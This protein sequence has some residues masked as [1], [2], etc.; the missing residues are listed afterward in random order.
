MKKVDG[1]YEVVLPLGSG[2]SGEVF[3]VKDPGGRKIALKFLKSWQPGATEEEA[4]ESFKRE[5]R[6]LKDL[7]HPGIARIL[8]FGREKE[9]GRY[10]FTAELIEGKDFFAAT[11]GK[12]PDAIENLFVQ[13][14]RALEYL[15]S[16]GVFHLDIKP[17]NL[18]VTAKGETKLIDFGLAGERFRGKIAGTPAYMAPEVIC[19]EKPDGRADLYSLGIVFYSALARENPFRAATIQ[20]TLERQKKLNPPPIAKINPQTPSYLNRILDRLLAKNRSERY[21]TGGQVIRDLNLLSAKNYAVET[22]ETLQSYLPEEGALVGRKEELG[23]AQRIC[24]KLREMPGGGAPIRKMLWIRGAKGTGKSRFLREL[25]YFCQLNDLKVVSL[26]PK[27]FPSSVDGSAIFLIDD[28][29]EWTEGDEE[30]WVELLHKTDV[31]A[32]ITVIASVP[33]LQ[34]PLPFARRLMTAGSSDFHTVTLGN[35]NRKELEEYLVS[36]TGL[37]TPPAP[38]IDGLLE[39]TEGNPLFVSEILKS[40]IAGGLLFDREGRWKPVAWEDFGIDFSKMAVPE[41]LKELFKKIYREQTGPRK[42]ILALV[43]LLRREVSLRELQELIPEKEFSD[44]LAAIHQKGV[45]PLWFDV[46]EE[47]LDSRE[48]E[49]LHDRIAAWFE[50]KGESKEA[51]LHWGDG[52]DPDKAVAALMPVAKSLLEG[53]KGR[54]A[55]PL[56]QKILSRLA[57]PDSRSLI[58]WHIGLGEAYLQA[59]DYRNAIEVFRKIR[60]LLAGIENRDENIF[61]K[62]DIH[63]KL[64]G[65]FLKLRRTE[66][67]KENI[68]AGLTL[69]ADYKDDPIRRMVLENDRGQVACQEGDLDRAEKIFVETHRRWKELP[70]REREKVINNDLGF[71]CLLK[72]DPERAVSCLEEQLKFFGKLP[73]RYPEA[74][75]HYNLAEA[76]FALKDHEKTIRHYERVIEL[77]Q[78]IKS[79]DLLL[80]AYNG[81]GNIYSQKKEAAKGIEYYTRALAIAQKLEDRSSQAAIHCNLGILY[82]ERGEFTEAEH[83]LLGAI[84]ILKTLKER[85]AYDV[86]YLA[87]AHLELGSLL[88]QRKDFEAAR[89]H[90]RDA[91]TLAEEHPPLKGLKFWIFYEL[92]LLYRD[93]GR[94]EEFREHL[95]ELKTMAATPDEMRKIDAIEAPPPSQAGTPLVSSPPLSS[96]AWKGLA[97]ILRFLSGEQDLDFLLKTILRYA[98]E[99]S[100]AETSLIL[101]VRDGDEFEVRSALQTAVDNELQTFST[102][103]ARKVIKERRPVVTENAQEDGRF[104]E[105]RS[106][107]LLG[108]RSVLALPIATPGKVIGVLYLDTRI[109]SSILGNTETLELLQAFADQAGLA[110]ENARLL[111][112]LSEAGRRLEK[113][114]SETE[115]ELS[116]ARS[117]LKEESIRFQTRYSYKNIVTRSRKMQELF[118]LL[119]KVTDT[120]IGVLIQGETGTGKELIAR[121]LHYNSSRKEKEFVAVNCGAI[122]AELMES[123]LF[124]HKAGAFTG[125]TR[126]KIG[127]CEAADGGTLFL[128]EVGELSLP[129]QVKLLR[130]LQEKE[131]RRVGETQV[132][133]ADVRIV[134][135]THQDLQAKIRE[136]KFRED[137]FFR[138]CE[139]QLTVPPLRERKEDIPLLVDRFLEDCREEMKI[140]KKFR[141]ER[142]LL[143]RMIDYPWPGNVRE[144]ENLVRVA[145][146]LAENSVLSLKS[147]PAQSPLIKGGKRGEESVATSSVMIDGRNLYRPGWSWAD[148]EKIF[149]SHAYRHHQYRAIPTAQAVGL[150][151]PT[152][153][154]KIREWKLEDPENPV[155]DEPFQYSTEIGLEEFRAKT[156]KAAL[157]HHK[158]PYAAL[159]ALGVSQGYF[160]KIIKM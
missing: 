139:I 36:L 111:K 11:E 80:R 21:A 153:Y 44:D 119:D 61:Y 2:M 92:T 110:I 116:L 158:R 31:P 34:N 23:L 135:A 63:E 85:S 47:L 106:V 30:K 84:R 54:E 71:V 126:D 12:N 103:I 121:A 157:E 32:L 122:P 151:P 94:T 29:E 70:V 24:L 65:V 146:A 27:N 37:E 86:T 117:L 13:A 4:L 133:R 115:G 136:G 137:L 51:A 45:N 112:E 8:D 42:K 97:K 28:I 104:A 69:L 98:L 90:L 130:F 105:A 156:F 79:Y 154:K 15:H 138:L 96:A 58:D 128:D 55:I 72:G 10:Y 46:I 77:A 14:L 75:C 81:L 68:Q 140:Q 124:G 95:K 62:V 57:S 109:Q 142:E 148:Y 125:A 60:P 49:A 20:E 89:D 160:Y 5:F 99:L 88:R 64:S 26:S 83:H 155:F 43:G 159:R 53:G 101:L 114:L 91:L 152:L 1:K 74:R 25:K 134:A 145:A 150:T 3:L 9:A 108:L 144:L 17:G 39:R 100:Q 87:R 76:F 118:Q 66:E 16:R 52:S 19:G 41:R 132:R 22:S 129:L 67:A 149:I 127:L 93:Q 102:G 6:V 73:K 38:L 48:K 35:F 143:R 78:P 59:D 7:N 123:E 113:K 141:I 56:F 18:L 120:P 147:L 33:D 50:K 82:Q 40:L 107:H 131:F